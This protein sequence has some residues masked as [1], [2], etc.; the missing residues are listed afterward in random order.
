MDTRTC[1]KCSLEKPLI[2]GYYAHPF[3]AAGRMKHCKECHKSGVRKWY[4]DTR[5]ARSAYDQARARNPERRIA[6]GQYSQARNVREPQKAAARNAVSNAVR[7]GRIVRGVCRCGATPTQA[8]HR[9][10]S[11][12][13]DVEWLCFKCHREHGHG[14]VVTVAAKGH[15]R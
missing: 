2:D 10:Y 13:L 1:S 15:G 3:G 12:P 4:A 9:D 7:D 6:R 14:Q 11:K 8:H 5:P